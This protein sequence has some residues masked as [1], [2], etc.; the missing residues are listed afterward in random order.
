M[1]SNCSKCERVK[2]KKNTASNGKEVKKENPSEENHREECVALINQ[3]CSNSSPKTNADNRNEE[4]SEGQDEEHRAVPDAIP[5][6]V[7]ALHPATIRAETGGINVLPQFSHTNVGG[8]VNINISLS[9][10]EKEDT[11]Q[12]TAIS[13]QQGNCKKAI[14]TGIS[15]DKWILETVAS[16]LD[17]PDSPMRDLDLRNSYL[18]DAS[19]ELLCQGLLSPHCQLEALRLSGEGLSYYGQACLASALKSVCPHLRELDLTGGLR[20]SLNDELSVGLETPH[21]K[22]EKLTLNRIIKINKICEVLVSAL[23]SKSCCLRMLDLSYSDM[24]VSVVELLSS[25]LKSPNCKLETFRLNQ[26]NLTEKC[27]DILALALWSNSSG[28]RE[29]ELSNNDLYDSGVK[30]LSTGLKNQHCALEK[31]SLSSCKIKEEGCTYLASALMS[32]SSRLKEL[33][34]SYNYP[35]VS[36]VNVLSARLEDPHCNLEKLNV[37]HNEECWVKLELLREYGCK[38]EFDHNTAHHFKHSALNGPAGRP[39]LAAPLMGIVTGDSCGKTPGSKLSQTV[40]EFRGHGC[41]VVAPQ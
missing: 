8:D 29:L 25:G 5:V 16:A 23:N 24:D 1:G 31:I 12:A 15:D 20:D 22:L 14:L 35:G 40:G 11:S 18:L 38:L 28:L 33:D 13:D 17:S 39:S 2:L 37:D 9:S 34:L 3:R 19:V 21:S 27:C 32:K 10:S 6:A 41:I 30:L 26:C 4:K 36:G 7:S